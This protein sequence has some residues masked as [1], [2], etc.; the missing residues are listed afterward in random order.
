MLQDSGPMEDPAD[1]VLRFRFREASSRLLANAAVANVYI[2]T[3]A[4]WALRK[5]DMERCGS[6]LNTA[7]EYLHF[8]ARW[9]APFMPK[10]AQALWEM[11]GESSPVAESGWPEL[12]KAD[13]W[14][15]D[16]GG[17]KLGDI[18][19]LFDKLDAKAIATEIEKLRAGHVT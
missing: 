10:K 6:V 13:T 1:S 3:T 14:R 15:K 16:L 18:H 9:M 2:D 19:G 4:P 7:V 17:Q 12:P 5:T 11:L 8:L